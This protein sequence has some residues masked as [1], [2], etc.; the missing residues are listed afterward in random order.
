VINVAMAT[1]LWPN[2]DALGRCYFIEAPNRDGPAE[3]TPCVTVVGVSE[4]S[5]AHEFRAGGAPEQFVPLTQVPERLDWRVLLVRARAGADPAGAARDVRAA[6]QGTAV[7]LPFADVR[8][9]REAV[10]AET[11]P[12][13]LGATMFTL[14]GILAALIA[15]VGLYSIVAYEM[16]QRTHEFGVRQAL[17]ARASD[18]GCLVLGRGL[19]YAV[20][21]LVLGSSLALWATRWI[22][23]LLFEVSARDPVV[24]AGV[25]VTLLVTALVAAIGPARRARRLD[26]V[27]VLCE[28]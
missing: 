5:R 22:D 4:T 13:D 24:F 28:E 16:A 23:S 18:V 14:F 3:R 27:R 7:N 21:G 8:F 12:W 17:G 11:R 2:D 15:A 26:A 10:A 1:Y 25:A 20:S 9:L 6:L 19:R